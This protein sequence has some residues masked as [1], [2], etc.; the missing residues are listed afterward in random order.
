MRAPK[1]T[2][3]LVHHQAALD[4]RDD[5][6]LR[7]AIVAD[8]HSHPHP[9]SARHIAAAR[10]D[11]ILH[12]GDIG[13]LEVL[14][15]LAKLAPLVAVRGNIDTRA[16][17]LPDAVTLDLRSTGA[18]VMK[19]LLLHIAVYGP[20]LRP[21][22]RGRAAPTGWSAVIRTCRSS[23]A[24][25]GWWCSIPARSGRAGSACPSCSGSWRSRRTS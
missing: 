14:D 10:P 23:G 15:E 9:D 19:I 13:D 17:T 16:D 7:L 5:G 1:T 20:K 3:R 25:A 12:A 21:A 22:W 2:E 11:A 24:I 8:T 18:S 6:G 4:L